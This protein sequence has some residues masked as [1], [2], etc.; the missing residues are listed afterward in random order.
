[1]VAQ[2]D[3]RPRELAHRD[4]EFEHLLI[5]AATIL[6]HRP[7]LELLPRNKESRLAANLAD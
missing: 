6:T 5:L 2:P 7:P 4:H 1:M 3:D